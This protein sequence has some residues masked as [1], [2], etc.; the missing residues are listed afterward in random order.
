MKKLTPGV[1]SPVIFKLVEESHQGLL[2]EK[3]KEKEHDPPTT[4]L[5][6]SEQLYF[7]IV[8]STNCLLLGRVYIYVG[9]LCSAPF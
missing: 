1:E 4:T 2:Q 3:G 5:L 6:P 7:H 9:L 8:Q